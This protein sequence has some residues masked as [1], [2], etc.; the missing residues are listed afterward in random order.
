MWSQAQDSCLS[1]DMHSLNHATMIH[2]AMPLP[3]FIHLQ[4]SPQPASLM[5]AANQGAAAYIEANASDLGGVHFEGLQQ[6]LAL[7]G[8]LCGRVSE[9]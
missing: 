5:M 2:Q 9:A 1:I 3:M 7:G 4:I 8:K 6:S